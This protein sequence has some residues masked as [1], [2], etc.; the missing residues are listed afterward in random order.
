MLYF[1]HLLSREDYGENSLCSHNYIRVY[2]ITFLTFFKDTS[3]FELLI[4]I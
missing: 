1:I 3:K 4:V 2:T